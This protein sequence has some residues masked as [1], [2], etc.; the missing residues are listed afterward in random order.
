MQSTLQPKQSELV[1]VGNTVIGN[2]YEYNSNPV[3]DTMLSNPRLSISSP[4]MVSNNSY[5]TM[6]PSSS[7]TGFNRVSNPVT[8]FPSSITATL[9]QDGSAGFMYIH[10]ILPDG[11]YHQM[12]EIKNG[13]VKKIIGKAGATLNLISAK[14]GANV[15]VLKSSITPGHTPVSFFFRYYRNVIIV[16]NHSTGYV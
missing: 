14:S 11:M 4:Q 10:S 12:A 16:L 5:V 3:T 8:Q 7:A 9:G 15:K 2:S 1:P 6:P 13:Y